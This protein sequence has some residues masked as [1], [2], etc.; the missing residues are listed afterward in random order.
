[1]RKFLL[2]TL[3]ASLA[4]T[5]C[6][7]NEPEDLFGKN[8]SQRFEDKQAELRHE[9]TSAPNGWRLTYF[10]NTEYFGGYNVLMK[11]TN[12]GLVQ[13]SSDINLENGTSSVTTSQYQILLGQG[14]ML[15]F[16]SKNHLHILADSNKGERGKGFYGEFEFLYYG[17][18]G[19]KL[20][21][22]TQ[23]S[24]TEQ[25]V[26]FEKA[27]PEEWAN[28]GDKWSNF[29]D[30]MKDRFHYVVEV[31]GPEG[32]ENYSIGSSRYRKVGFTSLDDPRKEV[33]TAGA[34]LL[35][36]GLVFK[37]AVT[38][39]G[40]EFTKLTKD[41]STTPPSYKATNGGVTVK[42]YYRVNPPDSFFGNDYKDFTVGPVL[43][44]VCSSYFFDHQYMSTY[45]YE[46]YVRVMKEAGSNPNNFI[47]FGIIFD[48]RNSKVTLQVAYKFSV[49]N[50]FLTLEC[51][52]VVRGNKMYF[53]GAGTVGTNGSSWNLP[54]NARVKAAALT[55]LNRFKDFGADGFRVKNTKSKYG[56][57]YEIYVLQSATNP[58]RIVPG[59][60]YVF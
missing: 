25:F 15:S 42:L 35:E 55:V 6:Q 14:T 38:F 12:D 53:T 8:A 58:E 57:S 26:Y 40:K 2:I 46:N 33:I 43:A 4:L 3:L 1:M 20:K 11:F 45:F 51:P 56:F 27:T 50:E 5:S 16:V 41:T 59:I 47:N 49:R 23:R 7:K 13:M 48:R 36:D 54:A 52:Y 39:Q 37:P 32:T 44:W 30:I 18:E 17:K 60:G 10:T 9:L 34:S 22:K 19:D 31:T 29:V 24:A 21:F 28:I